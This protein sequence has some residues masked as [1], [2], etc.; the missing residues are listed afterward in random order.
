MDPVADAAG[1]KL[2]LADLKVDPRFTSASADEHVAK[3]RNLC[4]AIYPQLPKLFSIRCLPRTPFAVVPT[5]AAQADAAPSAYYLGGA[6]DGTRPGTFYVNCSSLVD[7]PFYEAE[8][9]ALHEAIPGHHTQTMLAA[10]NANLPPFRRF[11]DDRR[12]SE[13]PGRY[14]ID[15]AFIE[16][17]G[18]YSESLGSELGCYKDPFQLVGRLSAEMFRACRELYLFLF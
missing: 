7:R 14:P 17:W 18:L 4:L 9:L 6:G 13:A 2:F 10:E 3:Y 12:Y 16:G 15:G 1:L 5:P 8:A 11:M